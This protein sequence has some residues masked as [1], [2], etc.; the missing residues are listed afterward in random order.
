M[1]WRD[2][3]LE[4]WCIISVG[5]GGLRCHYCRTAAG[6][7]PLAARGRVYPPRAIVPRGWCVAALAIRRSPKL[8]SLLPAGPSP[9]TTP[10]RLHP[11]GRRCTVGPHPHQIPLEVYCR[12]ASTAKFWVR[13]MLAPLANISL[14]KARPCAR[15]KRRRSSARMH[16]P[17]LPR[18]SARSCPQT[19]PYRST[20]SASIHKAQYGACTTH[21]PAADQP[22]K[23]SRQ[24]R[25][26]LR[27]KPKK[28]ISKQDCAVFWQSRMVWWGSL[29]GA[30]TKTSNF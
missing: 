11:G 27:C 29:A 23:L 30:Q 13:G 16:L 3:V 28:Q 20:G 10:L 17:L 8:C 7:A 22:P 15:S 2:A 12:G 6:S 5:Y 4:P 18:R 24:C 19:F 26:G 14:S 25:N 9:A 21:R 1:L